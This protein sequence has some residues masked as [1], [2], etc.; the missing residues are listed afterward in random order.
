MGKKRIFTIGFDLPG[1]D[2]DYIPFDSDQTLLD[3]DII[4]FKPML[5]SCFSDK[6]HQGKKLLSEDDSFSAK[7]HL[8]H[9]RSEIL[10][11]I[12]AGKLVI[13][14]LAKPDE[15]YGYT[16]QKQRDKGITTSFVEDLSSYDVLPDITVSSKS[17]KEVRLE[18]NTQ[19]LAGYWKEF[20]EISPY[21]VQ[22]AGKFTQ[23]ILKT[24]TGEKNIG[25]RIENKNGGNLLFLPPLRYNEE[26]FTRFN[27]KT[28]EAYWNQKGIQFGKRLVSALLALEGALRESSRIPPP[29]DWSMDSRYS[30]SSENQIGEQIEVI[31]GEIGKLSERK[32]K[33]EN[34]LAQA[35]NLR[36]LL[37][38]QGGPLE[39][40]VREALTI[41]GFKA[42]PIAEGDSEF[43]AI[44]IDPAG[45][46]CLG[47]VEGKDN[48]QIN[49]DKFSQLERNIQE[50]FQRE[51]ITEHAKAVLFGNAFRLNPIEERNEFFTTKCMT[52][53]KRIKAA[54]V[55]TPDMF[56][57][58]KY[59]KEHPEDEKYAAQCREA[60]ITT[61][62]EMVVFPIVPH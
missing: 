33:F 25:A 41:F 2:F 7:K 60:I 56:A 52:A 23:I 55:R 18:K 31:R 24:R 1:N 36:K 61:E 26:E 62:G 50:D 27:K 54:L 53:A 5:G 17:G 37:Y 13:I 19:F 42:M 15:C 48:K 29:P 34:E 49:I 43:D 39:V 20:S 35:G 30:L 45:R 28:Q 11:A 44:F 32:M 59:L 3:A 58:A 40:V 10:A 47:E 46:R 16:G 38:E 12:N 4:L 14:Y 8:G 57:P 51:G 22:I 9:W 6:K 21:E